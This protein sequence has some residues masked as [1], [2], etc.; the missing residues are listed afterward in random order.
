MKPALQS[1]S[2][3]YPD[4]WSA[5]HL[6]EEL[7]RIADEK[8]YEM[9]RKMFGY[10]LVKLGNLSSEL[11]LPECPIKHKVNVSRQ[12][13]SVDTSSSATNIVGDSSDLPFAERS[14]D[15]FVLAHELDFAQDPHHVLREVDR[16]MMPDGHIVIIGFNPVSLTGGA[17]WL[18]LKQS[19]YLH[20]ARC[21]SANRVKDWLNLL[22]YQVVQE[23]SY[24]HSPLFFESSINLDSH[25]S[26]FASKY[27][28]YLASVYLI[29]GKKREFPLSLIKPAWQLK[30]RF[31]PVGASMRSATSD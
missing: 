3:R 4:N 12:I 7:K 16:C 9:S 11:V 17:K 8:L 2:P 18:P 26:R 6:G 22:G 28:R 31:T 1:S 5:L 24:I 25:W 20:D 10:Y 14:I 27:L 29:V 15:A 23:Q 30:T 19:S 13:A 21:F